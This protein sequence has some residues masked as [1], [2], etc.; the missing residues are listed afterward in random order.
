MDSIKRF[1]ADDQ[2]ADLV[3]YALL[4]GLIAL[5]MTGILGT[6][7]GNVRTMFDTINQKIKDANTAA[8][9]AN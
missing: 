6:I 5:A 7:G 3:E 4:V 1:I 9:A 2:G 8:S